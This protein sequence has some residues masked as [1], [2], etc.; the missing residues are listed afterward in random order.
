M[1]HTTTLALL[2]EA[3]IALRAAAYPLQHEVRRL[4]GETG[5]DRELRAEYLTAVEEV[6]DELEEALADVQ[7][8][9]VKVKSVE[10]GGTANHGA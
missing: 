2:N 4:K 1:E 9:V 5:W 10:Y 3:A 8:A 6:L 7:Q